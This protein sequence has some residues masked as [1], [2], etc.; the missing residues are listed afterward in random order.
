[1]N[2]IDVLDEEY[3]WDARL[4]Y[5]LYLAVLLIPF[6]V[7]FAAIHAK[8]RENGAPDWL[9]SHFRLQVRTF[10]IGLA[11]LGVAM[12]FL[13]TG[14]SVMIWLLWVILLILRCGKGLALLKER[15]P[16]D[17]PGTWLF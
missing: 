3:I 13:P 17:N 11:Y 5:W 9:K 16:Y 1:M 12:L 15:E 8:N 2:T 14:I 7:P 4:G 10:W 6:T